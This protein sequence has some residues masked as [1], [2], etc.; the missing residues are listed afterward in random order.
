MLKY[1]EVSVMAVSFL[2]HGKDAVE[3]ERREVADREARSKAV[4]RFWIPTGGSTS[5]TFL[6]GDLDPDGILAV[7]RWYEHQVF[8]NGN[9]RNWFVCVSEDEVCPLCEGG[10]HAS[11]VTGFTVLDHSEYTDKK[12]TVHKKDRKSVV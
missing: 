2:K 5:I 3:A 12:G 7:P 1:R 9:W 4:W 6:D 11:L 8:M 10:D